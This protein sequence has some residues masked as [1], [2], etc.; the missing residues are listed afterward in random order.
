MNWLWSV[1]LPQDYDKM[2][3]LT[4]KILEAVEKSRS[5]LRDL[6][7]RIPGE[8]RED[9]SITLWKLERTG[10][11]QLEEG[12]YSLR[13]KGMNYLKDVRWGEGVQS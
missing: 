13:P 10:Y 4:R 11:V 8:K 6:V 7:S 9:I 3:N 1:C 5:N 12:G 2:V